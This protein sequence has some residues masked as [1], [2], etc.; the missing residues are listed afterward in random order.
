MKYNF[1]IL[2]DICIG[3]RMPVNGTM[4]T[5]KGVLK[6]VKQNNNH[7]LFLFD[8]CQIEVQ[9]PTFDKMLINRFDDV[10]WFLYD[11]ENKDIL[12]G[13]LGFS[14]YDTYGF[15]I[16][17]TQEILKEHDL[18]VD[19]VGFGVLKSMQKKKS[20]NTYKDTNAFRGFH[21]QPQP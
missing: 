5:Y 7:I 13:M 11:D 9:R 6:Q 2:K 16:E 15:P 19:V 3:I 18:Y 12:S 10:L 4:M 21:S 20:S 14:L 1:G 8:D 17:M